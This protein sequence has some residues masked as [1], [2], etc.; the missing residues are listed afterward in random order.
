MTTP[1]QY[2]IILR[3]KRTGRTRPHATVYADLA[4]AAR[5]AAFLERWHGD[6]RRPVLAEIETVGR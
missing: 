2:R 3:N 5:A 6:R 1:S 4:A